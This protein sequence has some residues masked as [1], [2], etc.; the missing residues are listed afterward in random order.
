MPQG[1]QGTLRALKAQWMLK[2][3]RAQL[4]VQGALNALKAEWAQRVQIAFRAQWHLGLS[5]LEGCKGH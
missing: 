2:A 5:G 4:M 3:L 1:A